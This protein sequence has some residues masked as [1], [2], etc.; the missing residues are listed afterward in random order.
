MSIV[1]AQ[2]VVFISYSHKDEPDPP[3]PGEV[4]WLSEILSY[5]SPALKHSCP[6][7][8]ELWDDRQIGGGDEWR[9]EIDNKLA[10]CTICI[11]LLSRYSLDSDFV[12][13]VE[14]DTIQARQRRGENVKI[15]PIV[16]SRFPTSGVPPYLSSLQ[17]RPGLTRPL[18]G[19]SGNGREEA[20][21]KIVDEIIAR[22]RAN[23][24]ATPE[25]KP[26]QQQSAY[27]HITVCRKRRMSTSSGAMPSWPGSMPPGLIPPS[28]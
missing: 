25:P 17:L 4:R 13:K 15:F 27:I 24:I 26:M 2:P 9:A 14:V 22:L 10:A 18:S 7:T 5:L 8:Y 6:A 19:M 11:L 3:Q 20:I 21:S 16:L 23:P 12:L 1:P 28:T